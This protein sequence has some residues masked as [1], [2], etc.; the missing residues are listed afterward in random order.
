M[1][2]RSILSLQRN[3]GNGATTDFLQRVENGAPLALQ[4]EEA[5]TFAP[6]LVLSLATSPPEFIQSQVNLMKESL[7]LYWGNY[8]D[9]LLNFQT[10]MEFSSEQEA[11]SK[12]LTTALKAV[13]KVDLDLFL[14]GLA[15]GCPELGIPIKM[16]KELITS[17]MEEYERVEK[18]EGEVKIADFLETTRNAV[19]PQQLK[20]LD[21][22]NK[23]V[24]PMQ[25]AYSQLT[26]DDQGPSNIASGPGAVLLDHLERAQKNLHNSVEKKPAPVFQEYFTEQ[27]AAI[28]AHLVGPLTAGYYQN[29]T[30]YL[31]CR[32]YRDE[33]GAY[34]VKSID[35]TWVLKTNAPKPERVAASLDKALKGQA[36]EP[37]DASLNKIVRATLEI[38]SGHFYEANDIDDTSYTFTDV[39]DVSFSGA[40]ASLHGRPPSEFRDAWDAVLKQKVKS[41]KKMKG[42]GP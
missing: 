32:I 33:K 15:E 31:D 7:N 28:G 19:G 42:S 10:S 11:E 21:A 8:R 2:Q 26:K 22:L 37:I 3:A 5:I 35:D 13:A 9:G 38:E 39:E 14:E 1:D 25:N 34:S 18:A 41:I 12:Y 16:A 6:E 20:T 40:D 27:F 4:R 36:K 29:A 24:R 23:Q 17:E 30:M